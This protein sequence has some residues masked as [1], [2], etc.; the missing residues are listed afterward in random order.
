VVAPALAVSV[1]PV[2]VD[3]IPVSLPAVPPPAVSPR[4]AAGVHPASTTKAVAG[5]SIHFMLTSSSR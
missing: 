4:S 5:K 1:I 3:A 2:S